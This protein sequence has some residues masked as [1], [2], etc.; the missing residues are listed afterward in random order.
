MH[1][2]NIC[3]STLAGTEQVIEKSTS[4]SRLVGIF[5][6]LIPLRCLSSALL[7]LNVN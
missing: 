5:L 7:K 2:I 3:K 1:N 4:T 6:K